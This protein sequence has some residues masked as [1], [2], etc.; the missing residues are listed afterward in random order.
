MQVRRIAGVFVAAVLLSVPAHVLAQDVGSIAGVV[1]DTSAA[2]LSGVT[3]EAASPAPVV[4]GV[5]QQIRLSA[6]LD[7]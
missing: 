2:V 4:E 6:Q 7:F 3:V 5:N 1:R